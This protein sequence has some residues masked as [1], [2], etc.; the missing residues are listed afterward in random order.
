MLL[1]IMTTSDWS[2]VQYSWINHVCVIFP[3][4]VVVEGQLRAP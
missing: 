3:P 2:Y 1:V 4:G